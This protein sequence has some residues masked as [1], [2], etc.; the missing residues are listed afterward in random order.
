MAGFLRHEGFLPKADI[1][2]RSREHGVA[3]RQAK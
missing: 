3:L 2:A 1:P